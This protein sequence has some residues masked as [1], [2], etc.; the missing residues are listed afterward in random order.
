M[1]K[2][3]SLII[4]W[5]S[6][7]F[8]IVQLTIRRNTVSY[9]NNYLLATSTHQAIMLKSYLFNYTAHHLSNHKK[10]LLVARSTVL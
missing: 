8:I 10:L 2:M 7:D 3:E 4:L 9:H 1:L 6:R 5:L